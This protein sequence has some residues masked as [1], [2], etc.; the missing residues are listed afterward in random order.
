MSTVYWI[1]G[2]AGAGKTTI[3]E[4]LYKKLKKKYPNTVFLDGDSLREVFGNDL[5]YS[6]RDRY[7]CAMR[8]SRLCAM[9]QKQDMQVICCTISMFND[10]REWNRKHIPDYC[11]IYIKVSPDILIKRDQKGLYSGNGNKDANMVAGIQIAWE[12]PQK[13]DLVLENMG[14]RTPEQQ[15]NEILKFIG[16]KN[17]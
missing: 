15:V 11:E 16:N 1:T 5:G 17:I 12:E 13:S 14:D 10:V 8:Y 2:L 4:L 6:E 7:A 3:G 9:L